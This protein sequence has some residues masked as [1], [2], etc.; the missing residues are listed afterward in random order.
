M[1]IEVSRAA[2]LR[3]SVSECSVIIFPSLNFT[4]MWHA[5]LP[6][7]YQGA[8]GKHVLQTFPHRLALPGYCTLT[9]DMWSSCQNRQGQ[10]YELFIVSSVTH[11]PDFSEI[12]KT[13]PGGL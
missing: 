6:L 12:I 3:H 13:C 8:P 11:S 2:W 1:V 9:G 4:V 5:L 7:G 10:M